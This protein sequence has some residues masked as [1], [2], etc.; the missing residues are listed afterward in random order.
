[1]ARY[2]ILPDRSRV[3]IA[4]RSNVHPIHSSTEGL[5]GYVD[6]DLDGDGRLVVGAKPAGRLSLPV[7]RLRSGNR[8]EDG[9]LQKRIDARRYPTIVGTLE[10]MRPAGQDGQYLASG[11]II[12]R[13]VGRRHEDRVT[14][15]PLDE[16]RIQIAGSSRFDIRE[17]G[18]DPPRMLMFRV[19]PEVDVR[20]EIVAE[21]EG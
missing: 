21:K 10:A 18:M 16:S 2:Q 11:E 3:W 1:M 5:E 20:V 8:L 4:A 7:S 13:G 15:D 6:I 9:E 12:F 14:L 19:E 17:F